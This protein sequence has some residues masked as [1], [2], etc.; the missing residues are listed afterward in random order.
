M[1]V[2]ALIFTDYAFF[3]LHAAL[4]VFSIV[5]WAFKRT[6]VL[7]LVA[8]GAT[9]FS[10]FVIGPLYCNK[11]GWCICTHYHLEVRSALQSAGIPGYES[12]YNY[13][14]MLVK[15]TLGVDMG[16]QESEWVAGSV[17]F[18]VLIA[19]VFTWTR[20]ALKRF[21]PAREVNAPAAS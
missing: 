16:M 6:R 15:K 2:G 4:I 9:A 7:H 8:F 14:Q 17:F 3:V 19:T 12:D 10:W 21:R 11:L 18:A 13:V 20:L 5:G 1:S